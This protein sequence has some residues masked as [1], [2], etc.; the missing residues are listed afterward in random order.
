AHWLAATVHVA[1]Q[2]LGEAER[3]L[4]AGI[5]GQAGSSGSTRFSSVALHWLHGLI[6]MSR[7]DDDAA[8]QAFDREN[9]SEASGHLYARE[10]CANT[11]YAIGALRLRRAEYDE[12]RRAF[13]E[14]LRRVAQH[15]LAQLGR[16]AAGAG[17]GAI[18]AIGSGKPMSVDAAFVLAATL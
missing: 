4:L 5:A 6:C 3:E 2:A 11:W 8:L 15:R 16:R 17:E 18:D 7:G 14:S 10:C 13:D 12:A 9:A 1:R